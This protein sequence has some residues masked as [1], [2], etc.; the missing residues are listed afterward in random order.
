M[1]QS[2][3]HATVN[4]YFASERPKRNNEKQWHCKSPSRFFSLFRYFDRGYL[5]VIAMAMVDPLVLRH[6]QTPGYNEIQGDQSLFNFFL[7]NLCK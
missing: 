1:I 2:R 5:P 6:I 3:L 4:K 7:W